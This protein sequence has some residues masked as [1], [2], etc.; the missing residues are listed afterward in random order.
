M[1]GEICGYG[2]GIVGFGR[3][4]ALG[5]FVGYFWVYFEN[6]GNPVGF[7]SVD[8]FAVCDVVD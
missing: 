6:A 5:G 8:C 4:G 3:C 1:G 2:F 7:E